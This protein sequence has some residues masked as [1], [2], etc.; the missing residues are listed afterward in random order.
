M[1]RRITAGL[2]SAALAA[3]ATAADYPTKPIRIII[4]LRAGSATDML[5]R[6]IGPK[7]TE[8]WGQPVVVDNRPSA[9]GTIAGGMVASA[10][11]DGHTIMFASS[12]FATAAAL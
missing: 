3:L 2:F 6:M 12:G 8:A 5:A 10:A 4:P 7:L 9:G 1:F 11:P